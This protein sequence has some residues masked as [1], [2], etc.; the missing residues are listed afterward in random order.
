LLNSAVNQ[1]C[2]Q[3]PDTQG[4]PFTSTLNKHHFQV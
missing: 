2:Q 3:I 4:Y 1:V